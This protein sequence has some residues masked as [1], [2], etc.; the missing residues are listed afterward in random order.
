MLSSAAD[1]RVIV[2]IALDI[3]Q[4]MLALVR[5]EIH[6]ALFNFADFEAQHLGSETGSAFD[7]PCA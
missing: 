7:I 6:R 3:A 4:R 5:L 2:R 1:D